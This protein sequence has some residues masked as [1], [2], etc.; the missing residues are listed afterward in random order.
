MASMPQVVRAAERH[1]SAAD[2]AAVLRQMTAEKQHAKHIQLATASWRTR[3]R[4]AGKEPP[5]A[6]KVK[7]QCSLR[8]RLVDEAREEELAKNQP[9]L[10]NMELR[11][12]VAEAEIKR[13][14]E[15][16]ESQ[17]KKTEGGAKEL[18]LLRDLAIRVRQHAEQHAEKRGQE[19]TLG[20]TMCNKP[21][22]GTNY[23][24]PFVLQVDR[25]VE[26]QLGE[27]EIVADVPTTSLNAFRASLLKQLDHAGCDQIGKSRPVIIKYKSLDGS[28][29]WRTLSSAAVK[30]FASCQDKSQKIE[31]S[32]THADHH[33]H[34]NSLAPLGPTPGLVPRM[35]RAQSLPPGAMTRPTRTISLPVI[36]P[37]HSPRTVSV[38]EGDSETEDSRVWQ[39]VVDAAE[40]VRSGK[41]RAESVAVLTQMFAQVNASMDF[42]VVHGIRWRLSDEAILA[43][44]L[45]MFHANS[46]LLIQAYATD[47]S[48]HEKEVGDHVQI[49]VKPGSQIGKTGVVADADC[50]GLV[51]ILG[52]DGQGGKVNTYARRG[53]IQLY[54]SSREGAVGGASDA[55]EEGSEKLSKLENALIQLEHCSALLELL[56]F[57]GS[58]A[59]IHVGLRKDNN[60][61]IVA[62]SFIDDTL[63]LG[64]LLMEQQA[65]S[66]N[67]LFTKTI[68]HSL[69]TMRFLL[70]DGEAYDWPSKQARRRLMDSGFVQELMCVFALD[71]SD[72]FAH[73]LLPSYLNVLVELSKD[74]EHI[75]ELGAKELT[76]ELLKILKLGMESKFRRIKQCAQLVMC[77]IVD[78]KVLETLDDDV[79]EIVHV[80]TSSVEK[81]LKGKFV[82]YSLR[83]I[84]VIILK[85]SASNDNKMRFSNIM[86]SL[87]F[88]LKEPYKPLHEFIATN[89]RLAPSA[90]DLETAAKYGMPESCLLAAK[91]NP[92]VQPTR[93]NTLLTEQV[94]RL[95]AEI[96]L[97]LLFN[98]AN[99]FLVASNQEWISHLH[100]LLADPE[101]AF[102]RRELA[103][104][105]M[106]LSLKKHALD[107]KK[108]DYSKSEKES[109]CLIW[110]ASGG[111]S[112]RKRLMISYCWAQQDMIKQVYQ[113]LQD[114]GFDVWLDIHKMAAGSRQGGVLD[115]M[116]EA[117]DEAE[118]VLVAV[119]RE[120]KDSANCRLEAEYAHIQGKRIVYMMTQED[121]TKPSGWLGM[122]VGS[123]LW[124]P[125]FGDSEPTAA[126]V[127]HLKA[128]L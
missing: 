49:G 113:C 6:P 63:G 61:E 71:Y 69:K 58:E 101:H 35:T 78:E 97:S 32:V 40:S 73:V 120:Y 104:I 117:I 75:A 20:L 115:A 25:R 85:L 110:R 88:V 84:L 47:I 56:S 67:V 83:Y 2:Q 102:M 128:L 89:L 39:Q 8:Q 122:L 5:T 10:L 30:D 42:P 106:K 52:D 26:V 60:K 94:K 72:A 116:S 79:A 1:I 4:I 127:E 38:K 7:S 119:S 123:K 124:H 105:F 36:E 41:K 98:E 121:F 100:T 13:L 54:D 24:I 29:K 50:N 44:I 17:A 76:D 70:T 45:Q 103:G 21:A 18:R 31:I 33:L 111:A 11:A 92:D 114:E 112:P 66:T 87:I 28:G 34:S 96:F 68:N 55:K 9:R 81:K 12:R 3:S 125:L 27:L 48:R 53:E 86:G 107:R 65:L 59:Q 15:N 91:R 95:A 16:L 51:K 126:K 80:L 57:K 77:Q 99:V 93:I 22:T 37:N 82:F 23:Q 109:K 74:S 62:S 19:E 46:Q 118:V 43:Q 64:R 108:G 14:R 90:E